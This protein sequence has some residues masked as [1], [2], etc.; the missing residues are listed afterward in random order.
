[1]YTLNLDTRTEDDNYIYEFN[2]SIENVKEEGILTITNISNDL[3]ELV[4]YSDL[5]DI[6]KKSYDEE[7]NF[8]RKYINKYKN[9]I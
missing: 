3:T 4:N 9:N 6:D 2:S 7:K 1:M 5:S 8:L